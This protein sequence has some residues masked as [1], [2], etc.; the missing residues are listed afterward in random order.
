PSAPASPALSRLASWRLLLCDY[1]LTRQGL[2]RPGNQ[3]IARLNIGDADREFLIRIRPSEHLSE[4]LAVKICNIDAH[5]LKLRPQVLLCVCASVVDVSVDM[6]H[7]ALNDYSV[8]VDVHE[9][10]RVEFCYQAIGAV[11]RVV[12]LRFC[13]RKVACLENFL[14]KIEQI[15]L[16]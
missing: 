14:R 4:H 2:I 15:V 6:Q 1:R 11:H 8:I 10:G 16:E 3:G 5:A 9:H 12:N 13:Y 7:T